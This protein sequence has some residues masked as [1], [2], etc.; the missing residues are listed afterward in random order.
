MRWAL[1]GLGLTILIGIPFSLY[2]AKVAAERQLFILAKT[3][4]RVFRPAILEGNIRDAQFQMQATLDLKKDESA[5]VRD[6][7]LNA[8]YPLD[9]ESTK[10][11]CTRP[12]AM[13]WSK[14]F[15]TLSYLYPIYFSDD[16][17]EGLFGYLEIAVHPQVDWGVLALLGTLFLIAFVIQALGL[18]SALNRGATEVVTQIDGWANHLR[19]TPSESSNAGGRLLFSEFEPMSSA[20]SGLHFEIARLQAQSAKEA[21]ERAQIEILRQVGHD[22][23]TPLSQLGKYLF[24]LFDRVRVAG[25]AESGEINRIERTLKRMGDLVRQI[26]L[27]PGVTRSDS[28]L[29]PE[30]GLSLVTETREILEDL[31]SH[32]E[33]ARNGGTIELHTGDVLPN[34]VISKIGYYQILE[35][36][37]SNAARALVGENGKII[38]R[39]EDQNG[40]PTLSVKDNGKGIASEIRDRI[41]DFDFTTRPAKGTGLGLGIVRR[42]CEEVGASV[43]IGDADSVGA[44]FI[45]Q[46]RGV[47]VSSEN[48]RE[49][50]K[51]A[52]NL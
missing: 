51:G 21:K 35:N 12:S 2:S 48:A 16:T 42:I 23:K 9:E 1:I 20:I 24:L 7:D 31:R 29:S 47:D 27:V 22:L 10:S 52:S 15:R 4:A 3:T 44:E 45:V 41:F 49:C 30:S 6:P 34:A 40:V 18:S 25:I 46:F 5:I 14:D 38:V 19:N 36:L 33:L 32:E 43:S 37:V 8:I 50:F 26:R 17:K 39:L 13:C 28:N 11:R